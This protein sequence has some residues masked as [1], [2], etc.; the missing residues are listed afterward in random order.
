MM[1]HSNIAPN[2]DIWE[3]NTRLQNLTILN[4]YGFLN[5]SYFY[6]LHREWVEI[7]EGGYVVESGYEYQVKNIHIHEVRDEER[8]PITIE[9]TE[10]Q[11]KQIKTYIKYEI[12]KE[13][14]GWN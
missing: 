6:D 2:F 9:F 11:T 13:Q 3:I 12:E 14:N 7:G 10:E 5:L 8:I 4:E 1:E